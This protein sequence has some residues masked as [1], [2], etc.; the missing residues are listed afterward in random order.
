MRIVKT[1][2]SDQDATRISLPIKDLNPLPARSVADPGDRK[3]ALPTMEGIH[4]ERIQHVVSLEAQGNYTMLYFKDGRQLLVCKTLRD[5]EMLLA[6][7]GQ[8]VRIHRSFTI[9]L[10]QLQRYIRG[11]GGYVIMENGSNVNVSAGRKQ[12]FLE[13]VEHYFCR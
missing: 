5:M 13:A 4:F 7:P 9:N 11:K 8:F 3:V 10:N 2:P 6:C 12:A 1:S